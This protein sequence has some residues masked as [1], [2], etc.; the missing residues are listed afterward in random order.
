MSHRKTFFLLFAHRFR[1]GVGFVFEAYQMQHSMCQN[2]MK[3]VFERLAHLLGVV[4]DPVDADVKLAREILA[5]VVKR[6]RHDVGVE[7]VVHALLV[8]L[9][10]VFVA[11][12]QVI[13][14]ADFL[15]VRCHEL[16]N[17]FFGETLVQRRGFNVYVFKFY[18]RF[19]I[20]KACLILTGYFYY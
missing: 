10:E 13:Q 3:L 2:P 11:A 19:Q 6:K 7:I 20:D 18:H 17:P 5:A 16:L 4:T 14:L 15:A 1:I 9:Q 12:E 8:E